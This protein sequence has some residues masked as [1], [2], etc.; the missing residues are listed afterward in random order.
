MNLQIW[1]IKKKKEERVQNQAKPHIFQE[2]TMQEYNKKAKL[3][4]WKSRI[5]FNALAKEN[6]LQSS[7]RFSKNLQEKLMGSSSQSRYSFI[8]V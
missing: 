1:L 6:K 4:T 5:V 2:E 8:L 3:A 7:V